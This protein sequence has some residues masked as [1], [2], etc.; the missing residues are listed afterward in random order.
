MLYHRELTFLC[1]IFST[2]RISTRVISR[3]TLLHDKEE[4]QPLLSVRS[5]LLERLSSLSSH[6]LYRLTD[7]LELRYQML[8][9][10][11]T[12]PSQLLVIGPYRAAALSEQSLLELGERNAIPPKQQRYFSEYYQSVPVLGDD[13][14]IWSVLHV[15]CERIWEGAPF[16]VQELSPVPTP[17]EPSIKGALLS[18]PADDLLVNMKTMEQRYAFENEM[19]R[20]VEKGLSFM[21]DRLFSAISANVFEQRTSDSLRNA[22]NYG[23]IMNTLLRK[24][25]ER[26]GVHPLYLDRMSSDFALRIESMSS[27]DQNTRL[28]CDMFRSYCRLVQ[29]HAMADLPSVVRQTILLIDADLSA[30]LSPSRLAKAQG[31]SLGYLS[32]AFRKATGKTVS[33]HV[34]QRRMEYAAYLLTST[35]L[36]IQTVALHC[37]ILDVQYFSKLFK[38][39]LR[40][41]PTQ[42]RQ[43]RRGSARS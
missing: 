32:S 14:S 2:N 11:G 4:P 17:E 38:G 8:L 35:N 41:T 6:T 18:S 37:G 43:A 40:Q 30:D 33:E 5:L 10:P 27:L 31:V 20:A 16:S 22:K 13:H 28:M 1:D 34:R 42:Y 24:A 26:G 36:Q 39:Y 15:F 3:E 9:L 19:I 12:N 29:E 25:A 7:L 23:V 21:E